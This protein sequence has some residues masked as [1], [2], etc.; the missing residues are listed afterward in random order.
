MTPQPPGSP[1]TR[2][3]FLVGAGAV[4][5]T[6]LYSAYRTIGDRGAN[7]PGSPATTRTL[8]LVDGWLQPQTRRSSG[9]ELATT[10]RV[11]QGTV[12][13]GTSMVEA[14]TYEHMY[15]G[16]TLQVRPGDRLVVDLINDGAEPT[17]IHTHGL[18]VSPR[19]PAD[20][21]FL[22][23]EPGGHYRY[24]YDIPS[25]HPAGTFWYH[26]H[27]G[28]LTDVQVFGGLFGALI[29]RGELD[30]LPGIAGLPERVIVLSQI[31]T[32]DGAI[33]QGDMSSLDQQ[34]TLVNGLYQPTIEG[35][36]GETQRWRVVNASSV[37]YRLQLED[38]PL[39][40]IAIDGNALTAVTPTSVLEIPPGGRAD[41]LVTPQTT[42]T[43]PLR[44]LSWKSF[45]IF[46][47][48]GMVPVAQNLV[49]L[50]SAGRT[51]A[52]TS[53]TSGR[54]ATRALLPFEDLRN[55]PI[56]RRRVFEIA[57]REPRGTGE[58][59]KFEYFINGRE[60][61]PWLVN[62]VM[63]LG[64]VEEWEM[65]NLTY[66]PHPI[67]IHVNP[68]QVIAQNGSAV[69]ERFYRDTA[70]LPPFGRFTLRTRFA[71]FD[72]IFVWHC[73]I[74]FHEDNGMMQIAEVVSNKGAM[75]NG[76]PRTL[77]KA[78]YF[79]LRH[80]LTGPEAPS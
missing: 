32:T 4:L 74:L 10:L 38:H 5:G 58:L 28:M 49:D 78:E 79:A 42:G 51:S 8:D 59:D 77:T 33:V 48:T 63:L 6:G 56:A 80:G 69:E 15:P 30:R 24:V 67:H 17:N 46:Y 75:H 22:A 1:V 68:F 54:H 61:D 45:G 27:W 7:S 41:V 18:H 50:H 23:V 20:N 53:S 72:G 55:V 26:A 13:I 62:D 66:E 9:G 73:H 40:I 34:V 12:P 3:A 14:L 21:I 19:S 52:S 25:N 37:F 60:F 31:Q 39:E 64:T 65:V 76:G 29:V 70:L 43:F 16:P 35:A 71:D 36:P 11:T 57:E 44:S 2:R 47:S